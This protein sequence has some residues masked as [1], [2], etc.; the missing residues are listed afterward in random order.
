MRIGVSVIFKCKIDKVE[1]I[2]RLKTSIFCCAFTPHA[3][4]NMDQE[5]VIWVKGK[6]RSTSNYSEDNYSAHVIAKI[7]N[8]K[9]VLNILMLDI[10]LFGIIWRMEK[11]RLST[12]DRRFNLTI[13]WQSLF[14]W[15]NFKIPFIWRTSG[16]LGREGVLKNFTNPCCTS[17]RECS[18]HNTRLLTRK[19]CDGN[20]IEFAVE[21]TAV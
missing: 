18:D 2:V 7:T 1:L 19:V 15:S 5:I 10:I 13:S 12:L 9:V 17:F 11:Y 21:K 3:R 14:Q 8:I 20:G 4:S 6:Y 16:I